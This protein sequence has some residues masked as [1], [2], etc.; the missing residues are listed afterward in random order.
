MLVNTLMWYTYSH[1]TSNTISPVPRQLIMSPEQSHAMQ[2]PGKNGWALGSSIP[3]LFGVS[4]ADVVSMKQKP[5]GHLT[6]SVTV[7][8]IEKKSRSMI[9]WTSNHQMIKV[10]ILAEKDM[11][12]SWSQ[13]KKISK[14]YFMRHLL[15]DF[16]EV[17]FGCFH[18]PLWNWAVPCCSPRSGLVGIPMMDPWHDC[19][20]NPTWKP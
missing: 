8:L 4:S 20:L 2:M 7:L 18:H 9:K 15:H 17:W 3:L 12:F 10:F 5:Y 14:S 6:L 19:I 16:F 11:M 1:C 13:K